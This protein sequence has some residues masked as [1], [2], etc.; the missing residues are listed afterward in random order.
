[1]GEVWPQKAA[2]EGTI[3]IRADQRRAMYSSWIGTLQLQTVRMPPPFQCRCVT[4]DRTHKSPL[5]CMDM[6]SVLSTPCVKPTDCKAG[7]QGNRHTYR[8]D[9]FKAKE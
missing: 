7:K 8:D 6:L 1:M 2:K 5:P 3:C 4:E 9:A